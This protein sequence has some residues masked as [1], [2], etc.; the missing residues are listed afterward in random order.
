MNEW[1]TAGSHIAQHQGSPD[2]NLEYRAKYDEIM[3]RLNATIRGLAGAGLG[4]VL[5]R[6]MS[7]IACMK[8]IQE[9]TTSG[10]DRPGQGRAEARSADGAG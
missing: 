3:K 7:E 8:A 1:M 9:I 5:F 6:H 4:G 2:A 10:M